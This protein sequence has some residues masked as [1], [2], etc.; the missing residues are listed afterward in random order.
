[1]PLKFQLIL[2][3]GKIV[4]I[5][6]LAAAICDGNGHSRLVREFASPFRLHS[7]R[8]LTTFPAKGAVKKHSLFANGHLTDLSH[9]GGDSKNQSFRASLRCPFLIAIPIRN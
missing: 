9:N 6:N 2:A 8:P 7:T 5:V 3:I 1:M 4:R